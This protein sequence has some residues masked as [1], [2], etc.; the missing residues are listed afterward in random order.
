[1]MKYLLVAAMLV[2]FGSAVPAHGQSGFTLQGNSIP[3]AAG[4][5]ALGTTKLDKINGSAIGL[6]L[7]PT[8]NVRPATA[9]NAQ[10]IAAVA[11]ATGVAPDWFKLAADGVDDAPSINRAIAAECSLSTGRH[12]LAFQG[13]HYVL[14]TPVTQSCQ[15]NWVGKGFQEQ[16]LQ[17]AISSAPGTWFDIGASF[18][19]SL[20]P[21]ISFIASAEGSIVESLAFDEPGMTPPPTAVFNGNQLIGWSPS[22]WSPAA[23]PQIIEV[24]AGSTGMVLHHLMFDGVN[25]GIVVTGA[26]RSNIYDIRG[27]AFA[28]LVN[29]QESYDVTRITDIHAWLFWSSADPVIQYQQAN[30]SAIESYRNDTPFWDGIFAFGVENGVLID[31]QAD[32]TTT[33]AML[34]R[35]QCDFTLHCLHIATNAVS[36]QLQLNNI[37][38]YGQK[39]SQITGAP[40]TMMPGSNV[41]QVDGA[42]VFQLGN[43]ENYGSD[44]SAIALTNPTSLSTIY[45]A[46][47]YAILT[48]QSANSNLVLFP[49]SGTGGSTVSIGN[50]IQT[51]DAPSGYALTNTGGAKTGV[52]SL[53]VTTGTLTH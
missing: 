5:N 25:A 3:T 32:G 41:I 26:G 28:Y 12:D 8:S 40:V 24:S 53:L 6:A 4:F 2:L 18:I 48:R 47:V 43:F 36:V 49:S 17:T 21:P 20:T 22:T 33:G 11:A 30:T 9:I 19:G 34:S 27:Q 16:P 42:G 52:G 10:T 39:W 46:S 15:L 44:A 7:D 50:L 35:L 51:T 14:N 1:M 45:I 31:Q 13:R 29:E 38:S 37:R 23:Y